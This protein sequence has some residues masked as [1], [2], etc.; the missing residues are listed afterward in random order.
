MD[1][2]RFDKEA[3]HFRDIMFAAVA[4]RSLVPELVANEGLVA[5]EGRL[6]NGSG[7]S[8]EV[9][10]FGWSMDMEDPTKNVKP[11]FVAITEELFDILEVDA[12]RVKT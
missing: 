8:V 2:A 10:I 7:G 1:T 12:T 11:F 3:T 5:Y 6:P 9:I 4:A